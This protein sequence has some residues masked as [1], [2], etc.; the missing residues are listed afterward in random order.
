MD[1]VFPYVATENLV[2]TLQWTHAGD[3]YKSPRRVWRVE[4]DVAG[5]VKRVG[6][7]VRVL[8][9]NAG[10]LAALDQPLWVYDMMT[11]FTGQRPFEDL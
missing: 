4:G 2:S 1:I 8:V 3:Y 6:G 11:K 5:Y 7:L 9:R 10:H